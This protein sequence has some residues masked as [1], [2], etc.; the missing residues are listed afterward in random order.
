MNQ[1]TVIDVSRLTPAEIRDRLVPLAPR[2]NRK[3]WINSKM[4]YVLKGYS[5]AV[6]DAT[7][8]KWGGSL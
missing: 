2:K 3:A 8:I 1:R 4:L 7:R 6:S 5:V